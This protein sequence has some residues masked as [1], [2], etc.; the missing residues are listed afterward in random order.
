MSDPSRK[1]KL[2]GILESSFYEV[3][4]ISDDKIKARC[5]ICPE[6]KKVYISGAFTSPSNFTTHLKRLHSAQFVEFSKSRGD[7]KCEKKQK[8]EQLPTSQPTL[9]QVLKKKMTPK[10]LVADFVVECS[11]PFS[12]VESPSFQ[13]LVDGLSNGNYKSPSRRVLTEHIGKQ[14]SQQKEETKALIAKQEY[15]CTTADVWSTKKRSFLGVTCH[16]INDS[17][18]RESCAL[19]CDRFQGSHTFDKIAE[20]LQFWHDMYGLSPEKISK[21]VTDNASN[22]IKAFKEFGLKIKLGDLSDEVLNGDSSEMKAI[23]PEKREYVRELLV[24]HVENLIPKDKTEDSGDE[25]QDDFF[26]FPKDEEDPK[27]EALKEVLQFLDDKSMSFDTLKRYP[28]VAKLFKKFNSP[29]PSSAPV[30]R[31]FSF[32]N[33][34]LQARRGGL[35]DKNFENLLMLKANKRLC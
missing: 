11:Q 32:A 8:T 35:S 19:A 9:P 28:R 31:L 6:G 3:I 18:E 15:V 4:S 17:F 22:F 1:R 26:D 12:I 30:E 10:D 20:K 25:G 21:T 7:R 2:P 34:I 23:L 5:L 33:M 16:W 14:R 27:S 24:K 13:R 29:I